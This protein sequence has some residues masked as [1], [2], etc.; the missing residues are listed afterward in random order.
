MSPRL[1]T[2]ALVATVLLFPAVSLSAAKADPVIQAQLESKGTPFKIDDDNDFRITVRIGDSGRTQLVWVRSSVESTH[3]LK[4][5]E[6]WSPGYQSEQSQFPAA[7]AN[8]MLEA[9]NEL[10]LGAWVKQEKVAMLVIRLDANASA[11]QLDEA[12]DQAANAADQME[13]SLSG[14]DDL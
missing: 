10:K 1:F 3:H 5:R 13:L 14:K 6:I 8:R 12:I 11:D 7:I 9:S 2:A 4:V